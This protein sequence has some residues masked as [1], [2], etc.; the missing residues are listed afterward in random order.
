MSL[1]IAY[2][3]LLKR[4]PSQ[5]IPIKSRLFIRRQNVEIKSNL[6]VFYNLYFCHNEVYVYL[7]ILDTK[8]NRRK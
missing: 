1:L 4:Y 7:I 6:F 3:R 2:S 5:I 8:E